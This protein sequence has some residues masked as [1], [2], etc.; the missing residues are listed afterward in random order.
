M[1]VYSKRFPHPRD[2]IYIGRPSIYG[3]PFVMSCEEDRDRVIA[4]FEMY[5]RDRASHDPVFRAALASLRGKHL[6]CW[7]APKRCHGDVLEGLAQEF[8]S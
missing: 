4:E 6:L 5:A 2:A 1:T 7:C 3:N 8:T